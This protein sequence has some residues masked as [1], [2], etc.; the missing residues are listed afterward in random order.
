MNRYLEK[1]YKAMLKKEEQKLAE[2]NLGK[3]KE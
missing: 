1:Q 3:I 2:Y